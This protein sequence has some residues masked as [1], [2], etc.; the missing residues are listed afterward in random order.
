[1]RTRNGGQ[2][3][4]TPSLPPPPLP[5]FVTVEPAKP[6]PGGGAKSAAPGHAPKGTST[7]F[8]RNLP[9]DADEDAVR[10]AFC[11][12]GAVTSVRLPRRSD[13]GATKGFGYVQYEHAFAAEA[14]VAAAAA[15]KLLVGARAASVDWDTGAPKASFKAADGRAFV[16]TEE[17]AGAGK[18]KKPRAAPPRAGPRL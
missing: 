15:G 5:G 18:A 3:F 4:T 7:L 10:G 6:A 1:M 13:T 2:R 17:A 11:K 16:K 9:Y 12:F 14:A 8:C